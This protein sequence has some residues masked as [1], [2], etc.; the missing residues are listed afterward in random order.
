MYIFYP[1][2]LRSKKNKSASTY[3]CEMKILMV[4]LG[5]ICRSPLAEGILKHK[6]KEAGLNWTVESSGTNGFHVGE[7]PH[8]LSCK[9]ASQKG[10]DIS[11]QV[12][13]QFSKND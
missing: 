8:P 13:R 11:M 3:L 5:N 2:S 9:V 10:I 6:I 1:L 12:A 4:C 7:S